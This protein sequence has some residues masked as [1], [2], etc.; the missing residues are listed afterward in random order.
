[1]LG[2][3]AAAVL[4]APRAQRSGAF[5]EADAPPEPPPAPSP[6]PARPPPPLGDAAS[7]YDPACVQLDPASPEQRMRDALAEGDKEQARVL[8]EAA[9]AG[10]DPEARGRLLWL[11]SQAE[12]SEEA[13]ESQLAALSVSAHQL[14]RW[15]ALRL[16]ESLLAAKPAEAAK[17]A[18]N[19]TAGWPGAH[20]ARVLLARAY[21]MSGQDAAAEPLLRALLAQASDHA[22][23]AAVALPLADIMADRGT[24]D[25]LREALQ[26]YRRVG[27]R[28]AGTTLGER[29]DALASKLWKRMPRRAR[30][31]LW[32]PDPDDELARGQALMHRHRYAQAQRV[33]EKLAARAG[34]DAALRCQAGLQVGRALYSG[35]EREQAA[36]RLDRLAR[37][38]KDPEIKAWAR[39]Y[40]G[41]AR[42]RTA[43]PKGAIAEY[44]ALVR[45]VPQHS[46]ADD[47]LLREADA[48]RDADD[49][50]A[51]RRTLERLLDRYPHGDMHAQ[52]RFALALDAHDRG[53]HSAALEQLEQL[54]GDDDDASVEGREGRSDYWRARTLQALGRLDQAKAA[55]TELVRAW[56]LSYHAQQAL[57]RLHELDP[58]A[59]AALLG[60]LADADA[61]EQPLRFAWR[62]ELEAPGFRTAVELLRVGEADLAQREL[63]ALGLLK[64]GADPELLWLVAATLHEA[65]AYTDASRLVRGRLRSFRTQL[66]RGREHQ[67]WRIAYPLAFSPLIEQV[68]GEAHVPPELVRAIAREESDFNPEAVSP[69]LAYGLIQ[70]IVPTARVHAKPLGLPSDPDSLKRPEVNLRIGA[71][72]IE[73]LLQRYGSD[74]AIVPAAYNAGHLA[75]DR[76]LRE[77]QQ[78]QLDEWIE[79]IPYRETR[80]YTR[81][82][83]QSYGIYCWLDHGKL[84]PLPAALPAAA[85]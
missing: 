83:L 5:A 15:A 52:A 38:C 81:R 28:A 42:Q 37:R 45:E 71:H 36:K 55:Y 25:S 78:R 30:A 61:P 80:R 16:G 73:D 72:F 11:L 34:R 44:E 43:D 74:A 77:G 27:A 24:K 19:L 65:R 7:G 85:M 6:P 14:A 26:L 76:W 69:A 54:R 62:A 51:A 63:N 9:L 67:L 8:G 39:Y 4:L 35:R 18:A 53:D 23:A 79:H 70:V 33:Y 20:E 66:P 13:S 2:L 3:L 46:L 60:E 75:A 1:M 12:P 29:A 59:E 56:P 10:A 82:V 40:A 31:G 50:P 48:L 22:A 68:A 84:K 21:H 41:S 49:A 64:R 17:T 57:A 47:A 58:A 32:A